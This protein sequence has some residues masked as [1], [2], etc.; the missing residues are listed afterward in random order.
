[1]LAKAVLVVAFLA[2]AGITLIVPSFPPAQLLYQYLGIPPTT[3]SI[4][5]FPLALLLNSITNGFFWLIV[6]TPVYAI[7]RYKERERL[8]PMPVAPHLPTPPPTPMPVDW[9]VSRIPPAMT[10]TPITTKTYERTTTKTYK[11]TEQ[12]ID[13]ET[14]EGIG[15][16]SA[17]L[18]RDA[19]IYTVHDLL[20]AGARERGRRNL[21]YE[22]GVTYS[23]LQK[24]IH[25]GDLLRTRGVGT[26]Y[27]ALLES[28]G[29]TSV[30][31]LSMKYPRTL[32]QMLLTAN[33]E[34]RVVKR[35]P[36]SKTIAI[37][38]NNA[39]KLEPIVE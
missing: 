22:V 1:M 11:S 19:G 34:K 18:L 9:R 7:A 5:G 21:A 39:K 38:V 28:A 29:I 31:D 10:V 8:P 24:W 12:D 33:R 3:L 25:R 27:S 23:A 13:I 36:P 30:T 16:I 32:R 26:K 17:K 14:I 2:F 15:P 37:W 4:S 35:V 20:R 6:A